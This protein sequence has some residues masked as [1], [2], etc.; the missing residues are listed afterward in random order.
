MFRHQIVCRN[1]H[2]PILILTFIIML[3]FIK[4]TVICTISDVVK[5]LVTNIVSK[6]YLYCYSIIIRDCIIITT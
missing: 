5:S 6:T 1:N 3:T 2:I 4:C